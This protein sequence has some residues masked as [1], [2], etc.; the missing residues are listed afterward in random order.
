VAVTAIAA[1]GGHD[2]L[3][4]NVGVVHR[5]TMGARVVRESS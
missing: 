3:A 2:V 5:S 1:F 4:N